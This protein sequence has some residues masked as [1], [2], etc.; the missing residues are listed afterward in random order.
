MNNKYF[1]IYSKRTNRMTAILFFI[2]AIILTGYIRIQLFPQPEL[3]KIV[4]EHA[5]KEK[6][7]IGNRGKITDTKNHGG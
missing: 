1:E 5:Y 6:T 2:S 7:I 4:E 3:K